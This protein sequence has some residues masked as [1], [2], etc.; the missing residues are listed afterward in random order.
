MPMVFRFMIHM[1]MSVVL[2][3]IRVRVRM[4]IVR[5]FM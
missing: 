3:I 2:R 4:R 1:V 5:M